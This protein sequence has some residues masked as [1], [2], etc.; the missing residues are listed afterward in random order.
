MEKQIETKN[1]S[2]ITNESSYFNTFLIPLPQSIS[3]KNLDY[4]FKNLYLVKEA[5]GLQGEQK[6]V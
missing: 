6:A 2:N 1:L 3:E 4:I 5:T